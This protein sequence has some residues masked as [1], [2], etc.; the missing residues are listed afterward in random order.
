MRTFGRWRGGSF[1]YP[2]GTVVVVGG[3][4]VVVVVVG[5]GVAACGVALTEFEAGE[6]PLALDAMTV[7]VY[8]M[9]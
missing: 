6:V 4:V 3:T 2:F 5:G 1:R 8:W 7:K 9:N